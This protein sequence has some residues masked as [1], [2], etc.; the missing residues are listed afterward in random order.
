MNNKLKLFGE[1][2]LSAVKLFKSPNLKDYFIR[3]VNF[4]LQ[5]NKYLNYSEDDLKNEIESIKRICLIQ[6]MYIDTAKEERLV[7]ITKCGK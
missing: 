4:D 3:K 2:L 7:Q 5:R 6:N 1:E